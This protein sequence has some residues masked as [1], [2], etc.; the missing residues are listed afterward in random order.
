MGLNNA[1]LSPRGK[2]KIPAESSTTHPSTKPTRGRPFP[3]GVS[4]NPDGKRRGTKGLSKYIK[5][6][7]HDG[8]DLADLML[9]IAVGDHRCYMNDRV[10]AIKWL[11]D[12]GFGKVSDSLHVSGGLNLAQLLL[13]V[14]GDRALSAPAAPK[15]VGQ[16]V[17]PPLP[18]PAGDDTNTTP[19]TVSPLLHS[20]P[21]VSPSQHSHDSLP[22][23]PGSGAGDD[24][25]ESTTHTPTRTQSEGGV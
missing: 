7:T 15:L 20:P 17:K 10:N 21:T 1:K 16:V 3:K 11:A 6:I 24:V 5:E 2:D 22:P 18:V 23:P 19:A 9:E 4:G 14:K 25:V 12:R 13:E 8:F